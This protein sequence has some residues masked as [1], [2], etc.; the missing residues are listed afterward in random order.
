VLQQGYEVVSM[1]SRRRSTVL[2]GLATAI[3]AASAVALAS[4]AAAAELAT[5]GGFETGTLSGWSCSGGT[6]SVVTS[7]V[8]T[9][10]FALAGAATASDNARCTQT[11]TVS[12]NSANTLSAWVRGNYVYLGVT[13]GVSTWTPRPPTGPSSP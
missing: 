13:G 2:I 6:G 3:V 9:G 5:N 7:P 1:R 12:P 10:S 8:R 11:I 4:P